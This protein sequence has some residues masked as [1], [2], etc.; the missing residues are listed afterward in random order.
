MQASFQNASLPVIRKFLG[1]NCGLRMIR[2][3]AICFSQFPWILDCLQMQPP[4]FSS[5]TSYELYEWIMNEL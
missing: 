5:S 2:T 1:F 4:F 3:T